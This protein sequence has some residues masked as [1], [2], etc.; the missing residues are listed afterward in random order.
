M[1][2]VRPESVKLDLKDGEWVEVKKAL[3]VG[4]DRR[5]RSAGLK[6]LSGAGGGAGAATVDI[7]W[8]EMALARVETYLL[9][10]SAKDEKG[11]SVPVSAAAIRNLD[12]RDFEEIDQAIQAHIAREADEK[13]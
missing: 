13:K 12:P 6:R 7:D 10:W 8:E 3:T 5:F 9:D 4:E 11:K 2:F 1:R